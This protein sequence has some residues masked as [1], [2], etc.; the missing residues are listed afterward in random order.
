[1]NEERV[2]RARRRR[3]VDL[4]RSKAPPALVGAVPSLAV[5][6]AVSVAPIPVTAVSDANFRR[7]N[8][9]GS[10]LRLSEFLRSMSSH[11]SASPRLSPSVAQLS[12]W[13]R[14]V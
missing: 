3:D 6:Q 12:G 1:M 7:S 8:L 9:G 5:E 11:I 14:E 13:A 2:H 10:S 4:A